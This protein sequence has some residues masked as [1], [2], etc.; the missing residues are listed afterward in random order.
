MRV[1]GGGGKCW[2]GAP[3]RFRRGDPGLDPLVLFEEEL[4]GLFYLTPNEAR[5]WPR[6]VPEP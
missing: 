1:L 2:P 4:L 5:P 3:G 6:G